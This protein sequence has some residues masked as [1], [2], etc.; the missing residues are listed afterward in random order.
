[1]NYNTC[2]PSGLNHI[3]TVFFDGITFLLFIR[4]IICSLNSF[5]IDTL[6][7]QHKCLRVRVQHANSELY[8]AYSFDN[9]NELLTIQQYV[10]CSNICI[11]QAMKTSIYL[12]FLHVNTLITVCNAI[13]S[14]FI[15]NNLNRLCDMDARFRS[16]L[17]F[18][19]G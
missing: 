12:S 3:L 18:T 8:M 2:F 13:F 10:P 1:M 5:Q 6:V 17:E 16:N 14:Q 11:I 7:I 9:S 19:N 15:Q 4:I